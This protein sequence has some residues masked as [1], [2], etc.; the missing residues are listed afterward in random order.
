MRDSQ[1]AQSLS[2]RVPAV[3]F[4]QIQREHA[5]DT[6]SEMHALG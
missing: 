2:C 5:V 4:Y 1:I 3:G 6:A